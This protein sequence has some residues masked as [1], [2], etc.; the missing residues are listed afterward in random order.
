[1]IAVFMLALVLSPIAGECCSDGCSDDPVGTLGNEQLA[2]DVT[3]TA[4]RYEIR[5][6][7]ADV[8]ATVVGSTS[9]DLP[10]TPCD[11]QR[12][13]DGYQVRACNVDGCSDWSDVS[14]EVL[15][16]VCLRNADWDPCLYREHGICHGGPKT[17]CV[18]PC[19]P[20]APLRL[21]RYPECT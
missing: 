15:P 6:G 11:V 7:T 21:T 13:G 2:W 8:C 9:Y 12:T 5:E 10:R 16:Y 1:M 14:V 18:E 19:Y 20:G 3:P 17:Q 4:T